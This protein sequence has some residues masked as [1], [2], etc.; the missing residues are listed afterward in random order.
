MFLVT[1]TKCEAITTLEKRIY[2]AAKA[3]KMKSIKG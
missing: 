1:D 2:D 3:G